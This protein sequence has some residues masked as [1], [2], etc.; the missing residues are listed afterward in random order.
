MSEPSW[1]RD[2]ESHRGPWDYE[3]HALLLRHPASSGAWIRTRDLQVMSLAS[4]RAALLRV[5]VPLYVPPKGFE[6]SQSVLKVRS[7]STQAPTAWVVAPAW[8]PMGPLGLQRRSG[9]RLP[10][11][12]TLA[13][14]HQCPSRDSNPARQA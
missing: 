2:P 12:H 14:S 3:P 10:P 4:Y 13:R 7:P 8:P 6:P 11:T 5:A 1:E 9:C